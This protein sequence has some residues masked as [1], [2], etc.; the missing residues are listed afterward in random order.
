MQPSG[1]SLRDLGGSPSP[2][3]P[4]VLFLMSS[5]VLRPPS[6]GVLLGSRH[7]GEYNPP[8]GG[9]Y[10]PSFLLPRRSVTGGLTGRPPDPLAL[11]PSAY[12]QLAGLG[13]PGFARHGPRPKASQLAVGRRPCGPAGHWLLRSQAPSE[14][15][16]FFFRKLALRAS[17]LPS[18]RE[19]FPSER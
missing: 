6:E 12:S 5:V 19:A 4:P 18:A 10:S 14:L 9:V 2:L 1:L 16:A 3:T 15:G 8:K 11:W 13:P 17:A 7:S